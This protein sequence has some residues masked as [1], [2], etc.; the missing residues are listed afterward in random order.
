MLHFKKS[1]NYRNYNVNLRVLHSI[2]FHDQFQSAHQ[3]QRVHRNLYGEDQDHDFCDIQFLDMVGR[4]SIPHIT[5]SGKDIVDIDSSAK[6]MTSAGL[7]AMFG[8][9]PVPSKEK[10]NKPK[11]EVQTNL[12]KCLV[13]FHCLTAAC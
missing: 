4:S 2:L 6:Q 3:Y 12:R 5:C 8:K 1:Y 11:E 13:K 9:M 7:M 10:S